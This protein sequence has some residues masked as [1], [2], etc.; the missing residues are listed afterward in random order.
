MV[1]DQ[2]GV[3]ARGRPSILTGVPYALAAAALFGASTPL[4]KVLVGQVPPVLLA[5]LLYLGSGVG[6]AALW[7]VRSRVPGGSQEARLRA[8][9]VPWLAGAIAAGGVVG[10]VLL[11]VGLG[12]TPGSTSSLLLN[13]EGVFT[14]GLA[15]VVF[16]E[17]Y[18]ARILLGMVAIVLGGGVLTWS[19]SL[20]L[21]GWLGPL[22]ILGACLAWGIDNNLTRKVSGGDPVQVA[23]LKGGIAGAVNLLIALSIGCRL[24]APVTLVEA[25]VVG[26]VGYGLS[27]ACFVLSLRHLGTARTGAYFSTAPFIG[28]L[29]SLVVLH[30]PVTLPLA[31]AAVLMGLGVWLH[32]TERHAHGHLHE[33]VVHDHRHSHDEHHGHEHPDGA[34]AR[35]AHAHPHRHDAI[36]HAHPHYPDLHHGH[37]H[38]G[39]A[40]DR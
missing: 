30:D 20:E 18:D 40:G 9:D 24:P 2:R 4:A 39:R 21:Q 28:A 38:Q 5:G 27:L 19:G 26:F 33:A 15:W 7:A 6:L 10:P 16:R 32:L 3:P 22:A 37:A 23:C 1:D 35:G 13:M 8:A 34:E 29:L 14:A 11:M 36:R 25:G 31:G 17:N 12:L